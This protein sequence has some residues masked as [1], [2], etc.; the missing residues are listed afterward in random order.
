MAILGIS[1]SGMEKIGSTNWIFVEAFR[2]LERIFKEFQTTWS[3]NT[4]EPTNVDRPVTETTHCAP[5]KSFEQD[6]PE[7][8]LKSKKG[9]WTTCYILYVKII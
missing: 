6:R 2:F 4:D 7:K 8:V 1:H 9:G 3:L 5:K